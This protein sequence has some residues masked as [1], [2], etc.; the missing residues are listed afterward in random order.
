[1]APHRE[2]SV[3]DKNFG[4]KGFRCME[5]LMH[6]VKFGAPMDVGEGD[7]V[8]AALSYGKHQTLTGTKKVWWKSWWRIYG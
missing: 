4:S 8:H 2:P 6:V 1:M 3:I 7:D 5:Q